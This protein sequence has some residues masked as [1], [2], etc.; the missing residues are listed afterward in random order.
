MNN[1][2]IIDHNII[3]YGLDADLIM[4]A[5]ISHKNNIYLLREKTEYGSF[6]FQFED[7][8]FLYLDINS[9]KLCIL[10]E[11]LYLFQILIWTLIMVQVIIY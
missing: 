10:Q 5:L 2:E 7:Y 1:Q 8:R 4:L 11:M 3:I 9:L 6:S